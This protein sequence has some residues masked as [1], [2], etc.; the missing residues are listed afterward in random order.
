MNPPQPVGFVTLS[1]RQPHQLRRV[2]AP[3]AMLCRVR[4]GRK[5][6]VIGARTMEAGADSL[7]L[8]PAGLALDLA[9]LPGPDGYLVDVVTVPA[10]LLVAARSR[11]AGAAP[12]PADPLAL[13]VPLQPALLREWDHL[14]A[15][16]AAEAA[17]AQCRHAADGVLLALQLL[18]AAAPLLLDGRGPLAPRIA[19]LLAQDPAAEWSAERIAERLAI[20]PSTLRRRLKK[21]R[22]SWRAL[23]QEAR[24][25]QALAWLQATRR[26]IAEIAA[27]CGY[28]SASRFAIRFRARYGLSPAALRRAL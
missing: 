14:L 21:E 2:I 8:L 20:S 10:D 12:A 25:G 26:P 16:L 22:S 3:Q 23:L 1:A 7:V 24:L 4:H 18:G 15:L 19:R 9:N 6:L 5:R 28:S 17:P 13:C 11:A 27:G